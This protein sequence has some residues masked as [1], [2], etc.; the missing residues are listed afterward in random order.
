MPATLTKIAK[1]TAKLLEDGD[2]SEEELTALETKTET[3]VNLTLKSISEDELDGKIN[4]IGKIRENSKS[5]LKFLGPKGLPKF[6]KNLLEGR[7]EDSSKNKINSRWISKNNTQKLNKLS[8][9]IGNVKC[10]NTYQKPP[11]LNEKKQRPTRV[12]TKIRSTRINENLAG[13]IICYLKLKIITF[14]VIKFTDILGAM[15]E[16]E[17]EE[18]EN[19]DEES[20]ESDVEMSEEEQD[21]LDRELWRKKFPSGYPPYP[22]RTPEEVAYWAEW[23]V[24]RQKRL[25]QEELDEV[26]G[27]W[28]QPLAEATSNEPEINM[29]TE[30][31]ASVST[32]P[33]AIPKEQGRCKE[34][35]FCND[36][37]NHS[38]TYDTSST[39]TMES[40]KSVV[41]RGLSR[42]G[43]ERP[44]TP[45][46]CLDFTLN[47]LNLLNGEQGDHGEA[48]P[49][50]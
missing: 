7:F 37:L 16:S 1:Y 42:S 15:T 30:A 21:R 2:V 38:C 3:S 24:S 20:D 46:P 43:E 44:N 36:L 4:L 6:P 50:Q 23:A 39:I 11:G 13:E 34:G 41:C 10:K 18:V 40:V 35:N 8:T 17:N 28:D 27:I 47:D 45:E 32:K 25:E 9:Y 22:A 48:P 33:A 5:N 26:E 49:H 19:G 12:F 14:Y 31:P 29:P